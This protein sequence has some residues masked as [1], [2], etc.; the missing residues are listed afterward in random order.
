MTPEDLEQ[1]RALVR[2]EI[3]A[4][5]QRI[6]TRQD[7][8]IEVVAGEISRLRGETH[9]GFEKLNSRLDT[10]E[11]RTER[12]EVNL[13]AVMLQTAG[14]SK[15]LTDAE[16]IDSQLAATQAAQQKAID[17]L[18]QQIADIKRRLPPQ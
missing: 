2:E 1:L 18:Y 9:E 11:H 6:T 12:M 13:H 7:G 3:A 15:S 17:D 8:S 10:I 4:A 5:E 14:M 16:R